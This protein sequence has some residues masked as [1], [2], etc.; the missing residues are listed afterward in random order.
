MRPLASAKIHASPSIGPRSCFGP[1]S[2]G[3]SRRCGHDNRPGGT[4]LASVARLARLRHCAHRRLT[5]ALRLAA[6]ALSWSSPG[7][8]QPPVRQACEQ[9]SPEDSAR[10][11]TR[12]LASLLTP[13]AA[14]VTVS[15]TCGDGIALVSA[16]LGPE[17]TRRS[18]ALSGP[19]ASETILALATRAI[20]QLTTLS[21]PEGTTRAPA[22]VS[23]AASAVADSDQAAPASAPEAPGMPKVASSPSDPVTATANRDSA[24]C[25]SPDPHEGRVRADIALQSWGSKAA[26]GAVLGLEQATE[27]WTYAFLAGAARP[28]EQPA[29]SDVSEWTAAGEVGWQ[30]KA[31]LGVR[32][33]ARLG[34]SVLA[35]SP[36]PGVETSSGTL[37][38]AAILDLDFSRP[39]W[40]DRLGLAPG[41][42]LRVYSA[43]RAVTVEGEPELQ[44][45]TPS[46][47][48]FLSVLLRTGH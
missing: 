46:V 43:Q 45:S 21:E 39:V 2:S 22:D 18:V 37:K 3:F 11:E 19:I 28:I 14:G 40:F 48:A 23:H 26:L 15:I 31:T 6:L 27:S 10:V 38:S 42:G 7:L 5:H 25:A 8:T 41:V 33:S 35:I 16:S 1:G 12:L 47:H 29:L 36:D 34:L 24:R 13:E 17:Q 4:S 44:L 32:I 9:L 20:A 30:N